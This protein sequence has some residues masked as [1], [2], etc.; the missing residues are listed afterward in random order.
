MKFFKVLSLVCIVLGF[1]FISNTASIELFAQNC[2]FRIN[3][4]DSEPV[5]GD[6]LRRAIV[7]EMIPAIGSF[8]IKSF[9][10]NE[11]DGT[12]FLSRV[13]SNEI[14]LSQYF[15]E[16]GF[17]NS[18]GTATVNAYQLESERFDYQNIRQ[19]GTP[20]Y[21]SSEAFNNSLLSETNTYRGSLL[22]HDSESSS[23]AFYMRSDQIDDE[24]NLR[25]GFVSGYLIRDIGGDDETWVFFEPVRPLLGPLAKPSETSETTTP[26]IFGD[27]NAR[28]TTEL[29]EACFHSGEHLI[30]RADD[31]QI[32][33]ES[34]DETEKGVTEEIEEDFAKNLQANI[35]LVK[36]LDEGSSG[37]L[38][39]TDQVLQGRD[40]PVALVGDSSFFV[41]YEH[42][43]KQKTWL[44]G[45]KEVFNLVNDF[46]NK[47]QYINLQ[48]LS[49]EIWEPNQADGPGNHSIFDSTKIDDGF[50]LINDDSPPDGDIDINSLQLLCDFSQGVLL[51]SIQNEDESFLS[52]RN[53]RNPT[54]HVRLGAPLNAPMI[55][56]L[57][58]GYDLGAANGDCPFDSCGGICPTGCGDLLG[59]S[60]G[61]G[62]A[63]K[64]H[65]QHDCFVPDNKAKEAGHH[66]LSQHAPEII[67]P[68]SEINTSVNS[69]YQALLFQRFLLVT[70]E[71]AHNLGF[72]HIA[73][74]SESI[75]Q[76][77]ITHK[78][79]FRLFPTP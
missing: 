3:P 54:N 63:F 12:S 67:K 61:I 78:T 25:N 35:D 22:G 71:V 57:F 9:D 7:N 79:K 72:K 18:F 44:E 10:L 29:I 13:K 21:S 68:D 39:V 59:I 60:E 34:K 49:L 75:M 23:I 56:H 30:Y 40:L 70:H 37:V 46:L 38:Q 45:Q 58:T 20:I 33:V 36:N 15:A 41:L 51:E 73:P 65:Q 69:N 4:D 17:T 2:S 47:T 26:S 48:I 28:F 19:N 53:S 5:Q 24:D 8:E 50:G 52:L 55:T 66:S 64:P 16:F 43:I 74:E 14:D 1:V 32:T 42:L 76:A 6:E 77:N 31:F 62:G 27:P 11:D